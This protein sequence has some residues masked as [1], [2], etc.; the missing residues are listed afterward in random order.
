[1]DAQVIHLDIFNC[2]SNNKPLLV[3]QPLNQTPDGPS[4]YDPLRPNSFHTLR[5]P[6]DHK[7][8]A[9]GSNCYTFSVRFERK[10]QIWF[11]LVEIWFAS[12]E[13][14]GLDL[15]PFVNQFRTCDEYRMEKYSV[16]HIFRF[17]FVCDLKNE[18]DIMREEINLLETIILNIK[19]NSTEEVG[20]D[21]VYIGDIF[22]TVIGSKIEKPDCGQ[23]QIQTVGVIV[24]E[25][26][27]CVYIICND[28]FT[29][30]NNT[31]I[32]ANENPR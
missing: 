28:S 13:N 10:V 11:L 4:D 18:S 16:Q 7:T 25:E 19:T 3:S 23:I 24:Q 6:E 20:M 31:K 8:S 2:E 1:M 27:D 22:K 14:I 29:D 32:P 15:T 9:N 17:Y 12:N 5:V 26:I 21:A 30:L